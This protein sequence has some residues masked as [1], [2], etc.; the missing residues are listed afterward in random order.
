MKNPYKRQNTI[1]RC[2][3]WLLHFWIVCI[4]YFGLLPNQ[5]NGCE[6]WNF[7]MKCKHHYCIVYSDMANGRTRLNFILLAK[8]YVT[9]SR[10][11]Q[12]HSDRKPSRTPSR[13]AVNK[14][15]RMKRKHFIVSSSALKTITGYEH[16]NHKSWSHLHHQKKLYHI[17]SINR[18]WTL[19]PFQISR[20]PSWTN[21][22]SKYTFT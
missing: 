19:N 21:K 13:Y 5:L 3:F 17:R 11:H 12:A 6:L 1:L 2:L 8:Q 22:H 15:K 9:L 4:R 16:R 10:V 18:R 20:S 7:A 14:C